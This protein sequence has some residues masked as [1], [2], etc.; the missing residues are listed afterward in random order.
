RHHVG[1]V[2]KPGLA[3]VLNGVRGGTTP[4]QQVTD[5]QTL[6][7][8]L[9]QTNLGRLDQAASRSVQ[10]GD[11]RSHR[12]AEAALAAARCTRSELLEAVSFEEA[13]A[14]ALRRAALAAIGAHVNQA[15]LGSLQ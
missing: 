13:L 15:L 9:D 11:S 10:T 7:R 14:H 3:H 2:G 4:V 8:R 1:V 5:E 6:L 12:R